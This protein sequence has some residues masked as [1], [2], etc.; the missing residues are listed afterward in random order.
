MQFGRRPPLV[1][2]TK[3]PSQTV[4]NGPDLSGEMVLIRLQRVNTRMVKVLRGGGV[5]RRRLGSCDPELSSRP[6]MGDEDVGTGLN[7][8]KPVHCRGG[9]GG[10]SYRSWFS[11]SLTW[12]WAPGD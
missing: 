6:M 2:M 3:N 5:G 7:G 12:T 1:A 8:S 9:A 4:T 11:T 10:R